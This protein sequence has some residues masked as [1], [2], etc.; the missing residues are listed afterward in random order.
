MNTSTDEGY[1]AA[2]E[3]AEMAQADW[4]GNE[5]EAL[6]GKSADAVSEFR[7]KFLKSSILALYDGRSKEWTRREIMDWVESDRPHS[8]SFRVCVRQED[9]DPDEF[10]Q[11]LT[12][13]LKRKGL[14]SRSQEE[15][16]QEVLEKLR[17]FH[18]QVSWG[19]LSYFD[20]CEA[21]EEFEREE[22]KRK[23]AEARRQ[24]QAEK[25]AGLLESFQLV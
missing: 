22:R 15:I 21:L 25:A 1:L 8:L 23:A 9:A 10:Q 7:R 4:L 16:H 2:S 17:A 13:D 14:M 18:P 19:T 20:A 24:R 5:L 12:E 11:L 3:S 6:A